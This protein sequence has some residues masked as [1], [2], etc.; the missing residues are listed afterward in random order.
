MIKK[1]SASNY[2]A[3]LEVI[4]RAALVFKGVIPD[5]RWKEPY[6]SKEELK[7]EIDEGVEFFGYYENDTLVGVMGMQS[8]KDVTL[9]R[10]AYVV[11]KYQ[12][13]GIGEKIL[14]K[15]IVLTKTP[16]VLVGTWE[17]ATWAINFY[18]KHGF[19][20]V[21]KKEKDKLLNKY[22]KIPKRQIETSVVLRFK[23]SWLS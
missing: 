4:N 9:I 23:K 13:K 17:A 6:M 1:L 12:N 10:H 8:V 15:L 14:K 20:L 3:I 21:S 7:R 18:E 11:P 5:D 22:W 19:F 16:E 2:T